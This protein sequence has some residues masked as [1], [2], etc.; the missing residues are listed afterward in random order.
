MIACARRPSSR[1]SHDTCEPMPGTSPYARTSY[2]PPSDSLALRAA[3]ISS[4]IAWLASGS[5]QRTGDSS[6]PSN[7][8][9]SSD[10]GS[11][12]RMDPI[13]ITWLRTSTPNARRYT[14]ASAP[15]ATRAAVSR[16]LARSSTF[17]TSLKPN[18]CTQAR[19]A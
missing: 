15:Q 12:A 19:S 7:S 16:A 17:R 13:W 14:L 9:R 4:T 5:R 18:F 6:T 10:S 11:G 3:S 1:P 2:T 8:S